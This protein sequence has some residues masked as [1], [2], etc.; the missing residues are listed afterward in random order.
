MGGLPC[1]VGRNAVLRFQSIPTNPS[2]LPEFDAQ[3][4]QLFALQEI[5][6]SVVNDTSQAKA[7]CDILAKS[8]FTQADR[9]TLYDVVESLYE[10]Y[11]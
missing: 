11:V 5:S 6:Q 1:L 10:G 4:R 2:Q 7:C 3:L 8:A 9:T